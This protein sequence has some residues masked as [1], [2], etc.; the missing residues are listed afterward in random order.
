MRS[1]QR[2]MVN[3]SKQNFG[4]LE[5]KQQLQ[6]LLEGKNLD[7]FIVDIGSYHKKLGVLIDERP[8]NEFYDL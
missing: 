3:L 2:F 8:T 7:L 4:K 6:P 1:L 5:Q